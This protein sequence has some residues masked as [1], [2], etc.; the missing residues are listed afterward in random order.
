MPVALMN[1][2]LTSLEADVEYRTV[3]GDALAR[4]VPYSAA[5]AWLCAPISRA[6]CC[7]DLTML[8]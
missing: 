1:L 2:S 8:W 3:R 7:T 4:R 5:L 6:P